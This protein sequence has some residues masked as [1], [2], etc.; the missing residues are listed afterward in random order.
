MEF[1][2]IRFNEKRI[3]TFSLGNQE[4]CYNP[5]CIA[6]Q[7]ILGEKIMDEYKI[8]S[9]IL[10]PI[11]IEI[12]ELQD[13]T[14]DLFAIAAKEWLITNCHIIE[15]RAIWEYNYEC[16]Y[17]GE[18][19]RTPWYSAYAQ[20]YIAEAF[21]YWYKFSNE[22]QYYLLAQKAILQLI[23]P[24]RKGG[25]STRLYKGIWFEEIPYGKCTHIFNAHLMS[26]ISLI[27]A[28]NK[29]NMK[30]DKYIK[31]ALKAFNK[32][33]YNMDT[34]INSA[35]EI[36]CDK[37]IEL[38]VLPYDNTPILLKRIQIID[39]YKRRT[40]NLNNSDCFKE[41]KQMISGVD[42]IRDKTEGLTLLKKND[43]EQHTYLYFY[44]LN[45][46]SKNITFI[47]NY[48]VERDTKLY[49]EKKCYESGYKK[50]ENGGNI[51]LVAKKKRVKTKIP[52]ISF[53]PYLSKVYHE[54]HISLLKGI[55]KRLENE[56]YSE[57]II[58]F[59][60]YLK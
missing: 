53:V 44:N 13:N 51:L 37:N 38:R 54:Y 41:G 10:K 9:G 45:S 47:L 8:Q 7:A 56:P 55:N 18:L 52:T 33:V 39:G 22:Q 43:D 49:F 57:L 50:L 21:M 3:F 6:L 34:G 20:A 42:W 60:S 2:S 48:E 46:N 24:I 59:E 32:S 28:K 12:D 30:L 1:N 16:N 23:C 4:E 40:L 25:C 11:F 14:M 58:R 19:L 26:I 17:Y 29:L 5:Y 15:N 35:Y 31:N 27:D 36:L